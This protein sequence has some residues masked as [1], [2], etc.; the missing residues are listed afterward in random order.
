MEE[1][2]EDNEDEGS[3]ALMNSGIGENV[4]VHTDDDGEMVDDETVVVG[5]LEGILE[6][7]EDPITADDLEKS[8]M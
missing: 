8:F 2:A 1:N 6:E 3:C 4:A 5:G 7:E